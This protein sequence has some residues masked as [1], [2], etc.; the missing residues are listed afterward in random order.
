MNES[1]LQ[2]LSEIIIK[3]KNV[4]VFTRNNKKIIGYLRAFDKHFNLILE[5][6]REIWSSR[7]KRQNLKFHERLIQK[8]IIRGD[9]VILLLPN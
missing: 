5:N 9:S 7:K 8:L 4:I 3:R 1:P 2:L 6:V